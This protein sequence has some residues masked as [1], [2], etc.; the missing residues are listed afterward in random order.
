MTTQLNIGQVALGAFLIPW[1][2][3]AAFGRALGI[4]LTLIVTLMLSWYYSSVHLPELLNWVLYVAYGA[5]FAVFAVTCHRLV[6]LDS[7]HIASRMVPRWSWRE[8]RFLLW[9]AAVSLIFVGMV[10]A[11]TTLLLNVWLPLI[12]APNSEW[13]GWAILA[14]KVPAFYVMARLCVVFPATAVDRKVNLKWAWNLTANNGWRLVLLVAVLPWGISELINLIYREN[15]SVLETI[16]L[17][18]LGWAL[19]AV[20][21]AAI[22]LSYR[23]LTK[24]EPANA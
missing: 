20:Q 8:I 23:E 4:P 24:H 6:L 7:A 19:V 15:A 13:P 16:I 21:V 18:T 11:V 22:S 10:I 9:M 5:L 3:R 12:T 14:A 1:W 17:T 2:N